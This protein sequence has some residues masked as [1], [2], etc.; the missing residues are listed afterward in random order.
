M[1]DTMTWLKQMEHR[2]RCDMPDKVTLRPLS[3]GERVRWS[4]TRRHDMPSGSRRKNHAQGSLTVRDSLGFVF[5]CRCVQWSSG[6]PLW[7]V[8]SCIGYSDR[9]QPMRLMM[10]ATN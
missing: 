6:T 3:I 1:A 2:L 5:H 8:A 4:H 9:S 10:H 7:E